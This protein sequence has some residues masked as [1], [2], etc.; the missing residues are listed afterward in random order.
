[1][2]QKDYFD[3]LKTEITKY[4]DKE[5]MTPTMKEH[6]N[7]LYKSHKKKL[8]LYM[9]RNEREEESM[10]RKYYNLLLDFKDSKARLANVEHTIALRQKDNE[11]AYDFI[12]G[13]TEKLK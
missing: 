10:K 2:K 11:K 8:E 7:L 13:L 3:E 6:Y 4:E 12:K 1:M 9:K 5:E